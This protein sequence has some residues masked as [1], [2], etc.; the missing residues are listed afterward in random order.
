LPSYTAALTLGQHENADLK[1]DATK[2]LRTGSPSIGGPHTESAS[3]QQLV[4][5]EVRENAGTLMI[6]T[7]RSL[8]PS[9][10]EEGDGFLPF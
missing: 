1:V 5:S 10:T 3:R 7:A 2:A 4:A 8:T 6:T 9:P